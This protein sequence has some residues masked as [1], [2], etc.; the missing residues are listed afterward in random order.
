MYARF[1]A[2]LIPR[3]SPNP[4]GKILIIGGGIANFTKGIIHALKEFKNRLISHQVKI[5]VRRGG[6]NYQEGLKALMVLTRPKT[7]QTS[8]LVG[9]SLSLPFIF[10]FAS[11][12]VCRSLFF[13]TLTGK[14][15]TLEVESSDTI[16]NV[17]ANSELYKV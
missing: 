16:D 15:I 12:E 7:R 3:G 13:K 10:F 17:K 5:F 9:S 1:L 4:Q 8:V 14:M 11:L 2:D 6:P